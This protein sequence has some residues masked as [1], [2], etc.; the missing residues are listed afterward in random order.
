MRIT[1][2]RLRG[3]AV[4]VRPGP[5]VRPTAARVR[6]ALFSMLGQDLS[7]RSTLDAF[8]GAGLLA[9]EAASRGA[10]PVTVCE[11]SRK[12][13]RAL[14]QAARA[15]EVPIDLRVADAARVLDDGVWDLVLLDPPYRD[16]PGAWLQRAAPAC[17]W[18]LCLEHRAG[19][20]LPREIAGLVQLRARRYGDSAVAIYGARAPAGV[21]EDEVVGEDPGVIEG[22]GQAVEGG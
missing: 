8:G 7:G 1:G 9:F 22:E 6:E 19:A 10:G 15:L 11:R 13:A 2:G 20:A 3:R 12:T 21:Q 17:R 14:Q 5:N 18:R 4:P 16:D